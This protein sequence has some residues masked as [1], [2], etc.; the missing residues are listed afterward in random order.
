MNNKNAE[1]YGGSY[2]YNEAFLPKD[3]KSNVLD[4]YAGMNITCVIQ[5]KDIK[6]IGKQI[7]NNEDS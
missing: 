5:Y 1:C 3:L 4:I 2:K 6:C 7:Q